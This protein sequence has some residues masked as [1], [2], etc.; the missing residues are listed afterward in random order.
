MPSPPKQANP[1]IDLLL[2][3]V[4]PSMALEWLSKPERLGP[5]WALVVALLLPL[6]FGVYCYVTRSGLN[7][8]SVLGLVAV[9]I[10]GGLG[11]LK[12]EAHWFALKEASVPVFLG[13]AFPLSHRWGKPLIES[14]LLTPQLI[15]KPVLNRAL[16]TEQQKSGFASLLLRAS[17]GMGGAMLFS[18]VTNF[19]LA[20]RLLGGKEPGSEA[21]VKGIGTLNWAGFIIIGVPLFGAMLLLML[22]FLK[23]LQ[24]L[25]G[26]ERDD[27]LNAGTTVKR[28]VRSGER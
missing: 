6:G 26:L 4:L 25:T 8:F 7:F 22:W 9:I 12:L 17:W 11:L 28:Q 18:A 24:Q 20:M 2:T 10:T 13:L 15:N 19:A 3:I 14:V 16:A 1:L 23:R 21:F 27:L 5:F